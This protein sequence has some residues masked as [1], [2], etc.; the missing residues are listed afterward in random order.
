MKVPAWAWWGR[1]PGDT[2]PLRHARALLGRAARFETIVLEGGPPL[3]RAL[4]EYQRAHRALGRTDRLLLGTA[5]YGLA[6]EREVLRDALP[7]AAPGR[8]DLLLLALLDALAVAP[9]EVPG[10]AAEGDAWSGALASVAAL[11]RAGVEAAHRAWGGAPAAMGADALRSVARLLSVPG[12]WLVQGP[13]ATLSE[14]V[15]ELSVLK[16]PQRLCLRA[17]AHRL[18]RDEALRALTAL[19]IPC[20]ATGRSPWGIVVEGRHNVL[21]TELFRE[22]AVEVQDEGSQLAACLCD[23][24][25]GDRVLDLCA[26]AGGKSLALAS[27]MDGRGSVVA[28]DAD[29]RRLA[30]ARRRARRAGL[31]NI[32][33]VESRDEVE[34]LGPYDLVLVDAPC[35]S[36]GTLRRNPDVAWRWP[37]E[38]VERLTATQAAILEGAAPLVAAGGHLV[39]VTCSLHP[40]ENGEQAAAFSARHPEFTP[41]APG[42]RRAH[43]PLLDIPGAA[44]G[45]FRLGAN[46][47]AYDGDAFFLAR[48]QRRGP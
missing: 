17:Q 19:G 45:A 3:D 43:G 8:G 21:A 12:W 28:H 18:G 44:Q 24:R 35:S 26:G 48:W 2:P 16:R 30:D 31:G 11:R 39:Y 14:A 33:I 15:G 9:R 41:A 27:L 5:V 23:P 13:W 46:L 36:S 7:E 32:R 22:G 42:D 1:G 34:R 10:L 38:A 25:P 40:A 29:A 6:R 20:R 47:G 4:Q 37:R